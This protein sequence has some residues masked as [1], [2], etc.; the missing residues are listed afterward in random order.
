MFMHQFLDSFQRALEDFDNAI[1]I[2]NKNAHTF[3][4]RGNLLAMLQRYEDAELDYS[5][6]KARFQLLS[7]SL[8]F[9]D[10]IN[11]TLGMSI[12]VS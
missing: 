3:Y 10:R 7:N 2:N 12:F 5:T 1:R 9:N 11:M 4:N 8:Y 6:G